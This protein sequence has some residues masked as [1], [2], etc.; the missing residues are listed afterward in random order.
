MS[1]RPVPRDS[2]VRLWTGENPALHDALLEQLQSAGIP[3]VDRPFGSDQVA[4]TADPL[5]I[6]WRPRFGFEVSV[7]SR[8]LSQARQILEKLLDQENLGDIEIPAADQAAPK[9][10]PSPGPAAERP[11]ASVWTGS[12]RQVSQF[13]VAA[14]QENEIPIRL[15]KTAGQTTIF[16][17]PSQAARA[18]EIVREITEA[19]PPT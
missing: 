3:Y 11:T 5:P 14:L 2:H 19:A 9:E 18:R 17:S 7:P 13:L 15:Q 8:H 12:D 4:P 10:Q 1:S 16:V 6:D